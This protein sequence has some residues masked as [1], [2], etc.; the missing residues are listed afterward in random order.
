M[1]SGGVMSIPNRCGNCGKFKRW[2]KLTLHFV[3]D[4]DFS[5]ED[6][7]WHECD[8]CRESE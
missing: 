1:S 2:E 3:P 7:S 4:T 5:S 8:D 6:E